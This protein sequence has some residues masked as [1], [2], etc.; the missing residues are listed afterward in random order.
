M[1][2]YGVKMTTE[3]AIKPTGD[4]ANGVCVKQAVDTGLHN[5]APAHACFPR[6]QPGTPHRNPAAS[7]YTSLTLK[8]PVL[9]LI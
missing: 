1:E 6:G 2:D 4:E 8:L 7:V 3:R 9:P 5:A